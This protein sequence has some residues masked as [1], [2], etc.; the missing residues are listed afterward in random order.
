[1]DNRL[2]LLEIWRGA[3]IDQQEKDSFKK[4]CLIKVKIFS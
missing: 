3:Q 2:T 4:P 1:M